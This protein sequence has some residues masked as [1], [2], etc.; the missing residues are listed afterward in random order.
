MQSA[1]LDLLRVVPVG[2]A[3]NVT[4]VSA[5]LAVSARAILLDAELRRIADTGMLPMTAKAE[6]FDLG[7]RKSVV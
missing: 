1:A 4:T 7:D 5:S 6:Q 2:A 3:A